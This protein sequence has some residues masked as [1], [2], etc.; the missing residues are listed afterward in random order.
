MNRSLLS[1]MA[2]LGLA[3]ASSLTAAYWLDRLDGGQAQAAA[4]A[5]PSSASARIARGAD[6]HYWAEGRIDGQAVRLLVDTG[7][8][9]VALTRTDAERLGLTPSPSDFTA[10]VTTVSGPVRAARVRLAH[11][12]VGGARVED[13]QALVF[14]SGLPHSL[15]GMSYLARLSGFQADA[16]GLTLNP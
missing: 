5:A 10:T 3:L 13:V 8:S 6:G 4:E 9:A 11:V 16:A 2:V 14:E 1:S 7:S 12:A 15:L